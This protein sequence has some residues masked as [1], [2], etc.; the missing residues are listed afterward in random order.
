MLHGVHASLDYK[1]DTN[2]SD[3]VGISKLNMYQLS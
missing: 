3:I 1:S 2:M